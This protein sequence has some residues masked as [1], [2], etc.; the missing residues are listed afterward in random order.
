MKIKLLSVLLFAFVFPL[1]VSAQSATVWV[2]VAPEY[3]WQDAKE[4]VKENSR[5]VSADEAQHVMNSQFAELSSGGGDISVSVRTLP[6]KNKKGEEGCT[7]VV[8]ELGGAQAYDAN[9]RA[10][11]LLGSFNI[12]VA[13]RISGFVS[14]KQKAREKKEKKNEK[15]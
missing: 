15:K 4:Y 7:I 2:K 13:A 10:N 6:E 12:R 14:A 5:G 11:A 3:C 9:Q 1:I 8:E